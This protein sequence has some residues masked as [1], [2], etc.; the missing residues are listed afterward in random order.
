[1]SR[2][3][4]KDGERKWRQSYRCKKCKHVRLSKRRGKKKIDA[5]LL[6]KEFA[7]H[8]QTYKE[9]WSRYE[10]WVRTVQKYLDSYQ[11]KFKKTV[12]TDSVILLIDTTYF[13]DLGLMV[14]KNAQSKQI[15][16][17]EI[18][19]YETN[20]WYVNGIAHLVSQWRKITAIVCDGRRWLL[21]GFNNIPTQM[22]H[23]HQAAIVRRYITKNPKLEENRELKAIVKWLPRTEK[24]CFQEE[25]TRWYEK[26]RVFVEEQSYTESW[27]T[28]YTHRRTRSAY[29]SLKRNMKY[30]FVYHDY[31]ATLDIP[32]TTNWIE[33][34]FSHLKYKVTLHR[35]LRKDRKLKL[36]S[37]LLHYN[38]LDLSHT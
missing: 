28:Y 7:L 19:A 27:K 8:K 6:Y 11:F 5:A 26:H 9:I 22:C 3:T 4:K 29:L 18:V 10:I 25:L 38:N 34:V 32:N 37:Y 13:G 17:H 14:F 15:L 33:A 31:L 30:L 20:A 24:V 23:F 16:H 12:V 36:I 35:W 21:G 2:D 1:M